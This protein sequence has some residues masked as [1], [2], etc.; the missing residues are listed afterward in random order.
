MTKQKIKLFCKADKEYWTENES[1]N[2]TEIDMLDKEEKS[3]MSP[4][5]LLL[6][7]VVSCAA[8]DIVSMIK[9]R[10]K[11]FV[12]IKGEVVGDRRDEQPRKFTSIHVHY[13]IISPDLTEEEAERIVSLATTK[14]CSV[15][16]TINE[17]TTI[18]HGFSIVRP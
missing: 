13:D 18:T 9:K 6:S 1:G 16:A 12:D 5:E 8:V 3:A 10:R 14:Y 4:M 7:G 15:A 17:S 2:K 11:T